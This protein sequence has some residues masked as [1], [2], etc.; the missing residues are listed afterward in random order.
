MSGGVQVVP[1]GPSDWFDLGPYR[2]EVF[3]AGGGVHVRLIAGPFAPDGRL[4]TVANW[5]PDVGT[6]PQLR[7]IA[8]HLEGLEWTD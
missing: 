8:D 5:M 3:R 4:V 2:A 6:A 1:K 7:A